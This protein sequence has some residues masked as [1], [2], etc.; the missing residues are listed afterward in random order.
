[1]EKYLVTIEFRY[2]DAPRHED[3]YTSKNKE[4]TVGVFDDFDNACLEG[5]KLMENLEGKF[6]L[7]VFP[8]GKGTAKK[9]R[10]SKNGGC[11]GSK[12]NLITN[13]AYLKTPFEFYAK[14]TTLK[15]GDIDTIIGDV[16]DSTKRYKKHILAE[17]D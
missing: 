16:N 1:M 2:S 6:P 9:E 12:K 3:D 10:F 17:V 11:F 14:I 13:L 7:H 5:N 15:Y 4:V 8:N